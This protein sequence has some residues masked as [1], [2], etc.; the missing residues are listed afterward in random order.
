MKPLGASLAPL[1][2][3]TPSRVEDKIWEAVQEAISAGWTPK[4]F[5]S[6]AGDAWAHEL[7]AMAKDALRDMT[8]GDKP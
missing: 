4:Q 6:E 1:R 2:V 7:R 3:I 5:R 8:S